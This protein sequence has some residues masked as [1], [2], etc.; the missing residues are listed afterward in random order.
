MEGVGSGGSQAEGDAAA[1]GLTGEYARY[2]EGSKF[3]TAVI[4]VAVVQLGI[5]SSRVDFPHVGD[6]CRQSDGFSRF[7]VSRGYADVPGHHHQ[8]GRRL[9]PDAQGRDVVGFACLGNGVAGVNDDA[10][11]M[12]A[13]GGEINRKCGSS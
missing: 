1:Y 4:R 2:G 8:I 11:G 6:V 12:I 9:G 5:K 10:K 7:G 3:N 13:V